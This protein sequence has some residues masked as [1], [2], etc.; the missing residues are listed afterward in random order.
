MTRSLALLAVLTLTSLTAR[1]AAAGW[2]GFGP[3]WSG[4]VYTSDVRGLPPYFSLYPP[5]YYSV[6]VPRTYGYSPFAYP[7]GSPTPD[8]TLSDAAPKVMVNPY[9][10]RSESTSTE[11][12]AGG[13][14]TIVNPY[15]SGA[16]LAQGSK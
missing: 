2:P 4:S 1:D 7:I 8:V 14:L 11:K 3:F 12:T 16:D 15:V 13:P 9:V 5:V 10:P 6:P